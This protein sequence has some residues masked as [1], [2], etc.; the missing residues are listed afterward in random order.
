MRGGFAKGR[1]AAMLALAGLAPLI[2]FGAWSFFTLQRSARDSA[3]ST[4]GRV[5]RLTAGDVRWNLDDDIAVLRSLRSDIS[6]L[7]QLSSLTPLLDRYASRFPDYYVLGVVDES[8]TILGQWHDAEFHL[9]EKPK[10]GIVIDDV[11]IALVHNTGARTAAVITATSIPGSEPPLTLLACLR[12]TEIDRDVR[13]ARAV[14]VDAD[15]HVILPVTSDRPAL[16]DIRWSTGR[17]RFPADLGDI[18][19]GEYV[20]TAGVRQLAVSTTV[21]QIG[22][23]V[24]VLQPLNEAVTPA[25]RLA[26]Q[27]A[28]AS[29][30]ALLFA[31]TSGLLLSRRLIASVRSLQHATQ[32]LASGDFTVRVPT[33]GA[34]EIAQLASSF[35]AMADKLD[36]LQQDVKSQERQ[37]IFG[38]VVAGLFHD[39]AHPIQNIENNVRLLMRDD[40]DAEGR[41][42]VSGTIE[43]EFR[44]LRRFMDDVLDVARPAPI[45]RSE[46][47]VNACVAEVVD[48]MRAEAARA[49]IELAP[50]T[51]GAGLYVD[52]D[53][54]ALSRVFRNLIANAIQASNPGQAVI[55]VTRRAGDS[56]E[57][58]VTDRGMGI[59]PDRLRA[60]FDDFTTT[61]R[62]GLGLGL[63][64]SKR[65]VEQ[66]GGTIS[67]DSEVGKGSTF[68]VRLQARDM[69]R[70]EAV[71]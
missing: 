44:A 3:I 47:D 29:I 9:P 39:V 55:V 40:L 71:G 32:A 63:A 43:R 18:A 16:P 49:G 62:R 8:G 61:K 50:H 65:I 42:S 34:P 33:D 57:I 13:S 27:L 21:P 23:R 11:T 53:A 45:G 56:A 2:G 10:D 17:G 37:V 15:N 25:I 14:L 36:E 5:A 64:T 52:G 24:V 4:N 41:R 1:L 54:F 60:I 67:V 26:R 66:M 58:Q 30:L 7:D 70:I 35:N 68:T 20:D 38:R 48:A 46:V 69:R 19:S 12:L 31:V 59:A 51:S 6:T 28:M 22:W